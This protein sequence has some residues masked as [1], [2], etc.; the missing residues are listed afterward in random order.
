[1][2]ADDGA[3]SGQRLGPAQ[4]LGPGWQVGPDGVPYRRGA[5]VIVLDDVGRVLLMRGNDAG[6]PDRHWWFTLGGGI[7]EGE[8]DRDAAAREVREEA[9][10]VVHPADLVGPVFTRRAVFDFFAITCRQDEVY[11][12]ARVSGAVVLATHGWTEVERR[13]VTDLR[14]W[15]PGALAEVEE[16]V[17]PAGLATL[18]ADLAAGWD[19]RTRRLP[20]E[21]PR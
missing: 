16:E 10:L 20:D 9:G 13:F 6:R 7:D 1:M 3:R 4:R 15:E 18:V 2:P 21:G 12:L 8:S 11:F 19:G 5:R 14:W 17:F